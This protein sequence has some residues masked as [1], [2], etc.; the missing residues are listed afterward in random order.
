M[1]YVPRHRATKP[2]GHNA[3]RIAAT[4]ATVAAAVGAPVV[5]AGT[6]QEATDA[7]WNRLAQCECS[8]DWHINTGNG[9]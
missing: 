2:T 8:G 1:A 6:A 9:Y 7:T 3:R 5:T 4:T